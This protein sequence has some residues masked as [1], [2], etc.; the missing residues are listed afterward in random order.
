MTPA[1]SDGKSPW[2]LAGLPSGV[3]T[4]MAVTGDG[5]SRRESAA[6][7]S[8]FSAGEASGA[9][10]DATSGAA[11]KATDWIRATSASAATWPAPAAS[12]SARRL[13]AV[14]PYTACHE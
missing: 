10:A 1:A 7:S 5:A 3:K 6:L 4:T 11:R 12:A 8:I 2:T 14:A 9:V 13:P